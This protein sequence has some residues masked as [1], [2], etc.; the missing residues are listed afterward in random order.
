MKWI[1]GSFFRAICA[2]IVGVLLIKYREETVRW[3]TVAMGVLFF[4]SGL[5]SVVIYYS[6]KKHA[7]D[8][9]VYDAQG[10][11]LTSSRPT[12]PIVGLGSMILGIILAMMPTTFVTGLTYIFA[13]ILILGAINQYANLAG[14]TKF[15]KVGFFY[16]IL[17]SVILLV[18]LIAVI[19]PSWIATAPLFIIGWCM[20]I[21]GVAEVLNAIELRI[22]RNHL[23]NMTKGEGKAI[24]EEGTTPQED[25][26]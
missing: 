5:I 17:P 14:V 2:I 4:L 6:G 19:K 13:A 16:W 10:K 24:E 9:Q 18:G 23:T 12:F 25:P 3:I 26:S 8:I 7:D 21:Y 11:P 22:A 1:H 15:C 20:V